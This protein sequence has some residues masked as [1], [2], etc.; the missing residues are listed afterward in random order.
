MKKRL[1][2]DHATIRRSANKILGPMGVRIITRKEEEALAK[3]YDRVVSQLV[4]VH[5]ESI[6]P[7]LSPRRDRLELIGQLLGTEIPEAMHLLHYLQDALHRPGDVCEMGVAQGATSALIANEIRD[8]DRRLWLYDSFE[9]LSVPTTEDALIDDIFQLGSM[10]RYAGSMAVPI[11]HVRLR[12][13]AV[14]FPESRTRIV[15]GYIRPD[16]SEDQLPSAVAFAYI[17][18]DLYQP[19]LTGLEL[20]HPRCQAGSILMVDD[21]K[22]FS[23]G[24]EAAVK[25]FVESHPS[26]YDLIEASP[27][28]G[29]FCVL[30]RR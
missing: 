14:Q 10:D 28:A 24:V 12:L 20:L 11:E 4:S 23:T 17:D 18:F 26:Q 6:F 9:G 22:Y 8:T 7:E 1:A 21:Y 27:S 29:H 16:L 19:I 13:D 30:R 15:V 2:V 5:E 3:R 25:Q